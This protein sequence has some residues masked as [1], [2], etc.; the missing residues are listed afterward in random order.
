MTQGF[1]VFFEIKIKKLHILTKGHDLRK[2]ERS[3]VR[4]TREKSH[5]E[6]KNEI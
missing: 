2:N 5:H 3:R 6:K 4:E 1:R